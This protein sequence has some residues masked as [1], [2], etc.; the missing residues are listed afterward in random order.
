MNEDFYNQ[1]NTPAQQLKIP[2]VQQQQR[3]GR[4]I[5]LPFTITIERVNMAVSI[6]RIL[7]FW[8]SYLSFVFVIIFTPQPQPKVCI[9]IAHINLD[10]KEEY[11]LHCT[12][13]QGFKHTGHALVLETKYLLSIL[14]L[15]F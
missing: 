8:I 1:R 4:Q 5:R 7:G 13:S 3:S 9:S 14:F 11:H 12:N 10:I 2:I 15:F 6:F